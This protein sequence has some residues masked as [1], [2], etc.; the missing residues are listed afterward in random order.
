LNKNKKSFYIV[1][2]CLFLFLFFRFWNPSS[3]VTVPD[4]K[5]VV[6]TPVP[7]YTIEPPLVM[8]EGIVDETI[9]AAQDKEILGFDKPYFHYLTDD[10]ISE[11][12]K[13]ILF[14]NYYKPS[15]KIFTGHGTLYGS[16]DSSYVELSFYGEVIRQQ[17]WRGFVLTGSGIYGYQDV[18]GVFD[19]LLDKQGSEMYIYYADL[20]RD[21]ANQPIPVTYEQLNRNQKRLYDI[22]TVRSWEIAEDF[23]VP[24]EVQSKQTETEA[25]LS[26]KYIGFVST[27]SPNDIGRRFLL[28]KGSNFAGV[29]LVT[30]CAK[31]SDWTG[32]GLTTTET[33]RYYNNPLIVRVSG[34]GSQWGFDFTSVLYSFFGGTGGATE[35]VL[36]IDP[37]L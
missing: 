9:L 8:D 32:V 36:A 11:D 7:T 15:P 23:I 3:D 34:D 19:N 18:L 22:T 30:G 16:E 20:I 13:K 21:S 6:N 35:P 33:F 31:Q 17:M 29:V 12:D 27:K 25:L 24:I 5:V 1:L 26:K 10:G 37:D 4:N 2:I 28:Y 14:L